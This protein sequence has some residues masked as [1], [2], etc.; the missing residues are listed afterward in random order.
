MCTNATFPNTLIF[1]DRFVRVDDT[2]GVPSFILTHF[3]SDHYRG[4]NRAFC[5]RQDGKIYCTKKTFDFITHE[6]L[7]AVPKDRVEIVSVEEHV[8]WTEIQD[9]IAGIV[10]MCF[11]DANHMAGSAMVVLRLAG[12]RYHMHTGDFRF[13]AGLLSHPVLQEA[14]EKVDIM[15]VDVTF[16][17]R[18]CAKF[19]TKDES[20]RQLEALFSIYKDDYISFISGWLGSEEL[21]E[22]LDKWLQSNGGSELGV[23]SRQF[24][25]DLKIANPHLRLKH[26]TGTDRD[27]PRIV[28]GKH[29]SESKAAIRQSGDRAS[30]WIVASTRWYTRTCLSSMDTNQHQPILQTGPDGNSTWHV[31][32]AMH[33]SYE[34]VHEL[35]EFMGPCEVRPVGKVALPDQARY[36]PWEDPWEYRNDPQAPCTDPSLQFHDLLRKEKPAK[37]AA[38]AA[39]SSNEAAPS[40]SDAPRP[41]AITPTD[42]QSQ[43]RDLLAMI[44]SNSPPA[45]SNGS[46]TRRARSGGDLSPVPAHPYA[47]VAAESAPPNDQMMEGGDGAERDIRGAGGGDEDAT[48]P[49]SPARTVPA[50]PRS[51]AYHYR[52]V[53]VIDDG[54]GAAADGGDGSGGVADQPMGDAGDEDNGEDGAGSSGV[55]VRDDDSQRTVPCA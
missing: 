51:S 39:A 48:E 47:A 7:L 40:G 3:H 19:I 20:K 10:E 21:I 54:P 41:P 34:E 33:S 23:R 5:E 43:D 9:P 13:Y 55:T 22:R 44:H 2:F 8:V 4:L 50:S 28:V 26:V 36:D 37:A 14:R 49:A 29:P 53:E 46:G 11:I 1:V 38:A 25:N 17:D 18:Q 35:V 24:F 32:W 42:S 12:G 6:D 15:Y 31:M 16:A 30:V 45:D 27:V 52:D